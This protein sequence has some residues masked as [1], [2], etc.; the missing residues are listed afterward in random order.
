MTKDESSG[1]PW[2]LPSQVT[3][4]L[5]C[6]CC[7]EKGEQGTMHTD[8]GPALTMSRVEVSQE[9]S[10]MSRVYAVSLSGVSEPSRKTRRD[11]GV[12]PIHAATTLCI[13]CSAMSDS[14][15]PHGL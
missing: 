14:L 2:P 13:S 4:S 11:S 9:C 12:L 5:F 10:G 1:F 15:R 7:G 8:S 3:L 6:G